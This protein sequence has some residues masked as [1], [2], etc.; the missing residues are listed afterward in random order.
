M[1]SRIISLMMMAVMAAYP[2]W[3]QQG[4]A[5]APSGPDKLGASGGA[6]VYIV[7]FASEGNTFE[8]TVA[9]GSDVAVA[10]VTVK[11]I[12]VP[13]WLHLSTEERQ[14]DQLKAKSEI[15]VTFTFD[16]DKHAI[17]NHE[18]KLTFNIR[19]STGEEWK[20]E[21]TLKV[22]APERFELF[23]NYPNPF[24]PTTKIEY[25]VPKG[26]HVKLEIFSTLGQEVVRL[27]DGN[28]EAGYQSI[29]WDASN[30]P[31]GVYFYRLDGAIIDHS[32]TRFVE[33]KKMV[34]LR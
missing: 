4:A 11:P 13:S 8:L 7:P 20:K 23:Q 31:S 3:S 34:V 15:T 33:I 25:I 18:Q 22:G 21:I 16:V 6:P 27:V 29:E 24:N 2:V 32:E 9:N 5:Q 30:I 12:E 17:A 19:T 28:Q 26:A 1:K 10:D 14:L